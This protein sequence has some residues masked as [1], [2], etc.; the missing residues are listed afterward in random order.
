LIKS[1]IHLSKDYNRLLYWKSY[2]YLLLEH[3]SSIT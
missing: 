3:V 2:I 1:I